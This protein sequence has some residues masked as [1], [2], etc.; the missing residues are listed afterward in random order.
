[1]HLIFFASSH[2]VAANSKPV[3]AKEHHGDFLAGPHTQKNLENVI[4][5]KQKIPSH[6]PAFKMSIFFIS[7]KAIIL[8]YIELQCLGAMFIKLVRSVTLNVKNKSWEGM[9]SRISAPPTIGASRL[10]QYLLDH[11]F[12]S[13]K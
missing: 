6:I 9:P 10:G 11:F 1:M 7:H 12:K 5:R 4:C 2:F 8:F 13:R 3:Y